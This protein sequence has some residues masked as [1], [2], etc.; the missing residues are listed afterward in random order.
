MIDWIL[1]HYDLLI[2]GFLVLI[3]VITFIL[4][5]PNKTSIYDSS[6]YKNLAILVNEAEEKFGA[7]KGEEKLDYVLRKYCALYSIKPDTFTL[8]SIRHLVEFILSTP[9]KKD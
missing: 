9:H 5:K 2:S 1:Q 3:S 8:S 4:R 6:A 7:G